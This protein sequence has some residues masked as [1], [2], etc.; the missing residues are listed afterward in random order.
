[1]HVHTTQTNTNQQQQP[2]QRASM[3]NILQNEY[4]P[5][6]GR[7]HLIA[8]LLWK[9]MIPKDETKMKVAWVVTNG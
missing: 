7:V 3:N 8:L 1:M 4:D 5:S 9:R 2:E 6:E